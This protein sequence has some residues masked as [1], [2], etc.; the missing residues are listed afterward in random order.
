[1]SSEKPR[2]EFL[3]VTLFTDYCSYSVCVHM[4]VCRQISSVQSQY[5]TNSAILRMW[6]AGYSLIIRVISM[7]FTFLNSEAYLCES[8]HILA[9]LGL[10]CPGHLLVI[11]NSLSLTDNSYAA[12]TPQVVTVLERWLFFA[13]FHN[14]K[15]CYKGICVKRQESR[16]PC[17]E[18]YWVGHLS[19]K[20][21][22]T[23]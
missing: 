4:R 20:L 21:L 19:L 5:D 13:F 11:R 1:M 16:V 14:Y 2:L 9:H 17:P 3:K 18:S 8:Q 10:G 22:H 23:V 12:L 6:K 7:L 15:L